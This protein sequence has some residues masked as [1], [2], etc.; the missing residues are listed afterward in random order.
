MTATD[1][2]CA[3]FSDN[4]YPSL[5]SLQ[6]RTP[7]VVRRLRGNLLTDAEE[8]V[9]FVDML[10]I[11]GVSLKPSVPRLKADTGEPG[12]GNFHVT[13]HARKR[14][15]DQYKDAV[16]KGLGDAPGLA[17]HEEHGPGRPPVCLW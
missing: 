4:S 10:E 8:C 17:M 3:L 2:L 7:K 11:R 16:L 12:F 5:F 14:A 15:A 6:Y 13:T 1:A 9:G